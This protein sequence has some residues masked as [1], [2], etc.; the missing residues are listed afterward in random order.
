M[1]QSCIRFAGPPQPRRRHRGQGSLLEVGNPPLRQPSATIRATAGAVQGA[2]TPTASMHRHNMGPALDSHHAS[3]KRLCN[4]PSGSQRSAIP[5]TV[6]GIEAVDNGFENNVEQVSSSCCEE[7]D[8]CRTGAG[9]RISTISRLA[10]MARVRQEHG[11]PS[12][13]PNS[14]QTV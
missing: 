1:W 8:Q 3:P 4:R 5:W 11:R 7:S 6:W 13:G 12:I 2:I 10:K 9:G 14:P